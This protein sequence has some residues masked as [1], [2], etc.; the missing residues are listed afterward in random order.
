MPIIEAVEVSKRFGQLLAVDEVSLR[1]APGEVVGLLGANG[2]GKTTL[3]RMILGLIVPTSG[4]IRLFGEV[5]S[6]LG[7]SRLG[8]VPQGTGLY[9]DLTV[10]ENLAFIAKAFGVPSPELDAD[11]ELVADRT[12]GQISLGLRKRVAFAG[13]RSHHPELLVLDEPTSG[14]GPLGRAELWATIGSAAA[15]GA[16]VLV[17][18]HHMEEAEQCDRV[19][20]MA[21]GRAV[22]E[23]TASGIAGSVESVEIEVADWRTALVALERAGF[24]PTLLGSHLRVTGVDADR[25]DYTLTRAGLTATTKAV[26]AGF[27]DA[28]VALAER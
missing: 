24:Q 6:R 3:I 17:T 11:L 2:A 28:F 16:G 4:V 10:G 22:A 12:V 13:A 7:R 1:V 5:P 21:T 20:M 25:I 26:P 19:V 23:G 27:E 14:V 8:Y 15:G 9:Q 18:T